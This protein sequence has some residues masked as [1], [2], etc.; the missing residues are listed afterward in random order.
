MVI[1]FLNTTNSFQGSFKGKNELSDVV[2]AP[3]SPPTAYC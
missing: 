3:K 2:A 1:I